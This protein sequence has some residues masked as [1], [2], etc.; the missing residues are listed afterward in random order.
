MSRMIRN[1]AAGSLALVAGDAFAHAL[2]VGSEPEAGSTLA[3]PPPRAMLRF[4]SRIDQAR[5][6]LTLVGPDGAQFA[7]PLAETEQATVLDAP[8]P[9]PLA[10]GGWRLRWQVLAA[11]G[12]ITRG[13]IAF[14]LAP[15]R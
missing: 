10:P 2:V 5:S 4:N 8:L 13:D 7:L 9:G 6:R 12:H 14:T 1:V 3:A 11:D 15:H